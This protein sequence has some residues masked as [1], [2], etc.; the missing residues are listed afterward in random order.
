MF[1]IQGVWYLLCSFNASPSSLTP[2]LR[3]EKK[4]QMYCGLEYIFTLLQIFINSRISP[5]CVL[6]FNLVRH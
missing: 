3:Q 1:Q 2:A 5:N 4:D 6:V